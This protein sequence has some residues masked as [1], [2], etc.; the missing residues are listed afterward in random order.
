VSAEYLQTHKGCDLTAKVVE[1]ERWFLDHQHGG[2]HEEPIA[3]APEGYPFHWI[4]CAC[5]AK[6]A[7][8]VHIN[9]LK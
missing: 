9:R 2:F 7:T 6:H 4:V 3:G 8:D 1:T 5:G